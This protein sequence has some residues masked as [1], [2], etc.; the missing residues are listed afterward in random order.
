VLQLYGAGN[1]AGNYRK[2]IGATLMFTLNVGE[3]SSLQYE[4]NP[5]MREKIIRLTQ[6]KLVAKCKPKRSLSGMWLGNNK[7]S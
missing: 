7:N 6:E 5:K 1:L 2:G 4:L 3:G